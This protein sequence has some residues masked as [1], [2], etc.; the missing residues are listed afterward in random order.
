MSSRD[1][2]CSLARIPYSLVAA[3]LNL[4][5]FGLPVPPTIRPLGPDANAWN[6]CHPAGARIWW[7]NLEE[8][9]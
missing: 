3:Y 6:A 4:F 7:W 1:L 5:D 2:F 9:E 8:N